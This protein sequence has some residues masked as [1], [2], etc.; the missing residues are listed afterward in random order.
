MK[1]IVI[2]GDASG[3]GKTT[4]AKETHR[5][6]PGAAVAKIGHDQEKPG[7]QHSFYHLGTSF[8]EIKNDHAQARYLIVESNSILEQMSPDLAIFLR[9]EN[10]KPSAALAKPKA[11]IVS[12]TLVD[13]SKVD[14]LSRRL[15][16]DALTMQK[17]IWLSGA[18]PEPAAAVILAGGKSKRMGFDKTSLTVKGKPILET[19]Y[20]TL[21]PVFDEVMMSLANGNASIPFA[22][23]VVSDQAPD[24]GP[25]MGIYS[26]LAESTCRV[27]LFVACDIPKLHLGAVREILSHAAD[28]DIVV[29]SFQEGQYEPLCAVYTKDVAPKAKTL[30]DAGKRRVAELFS[31]C[32]TRVVQIKNKQWYSNLNTP[33]DYQAF[34]QVEGSSVNVRP[35]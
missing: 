33:E 5:L 25:L 6:L 13:Q 34:L 14:N 29:P 31:R 24:C 7:Y 17:I 9:G 21:Q 18:R 27:N 30:L 26:S 28:H 23:K 16:I 35:I 12:G 4:L 19:L 3:V 32:N 1:T 2:S 11:D 15:S 10:P 22:A 20:H 8:Q